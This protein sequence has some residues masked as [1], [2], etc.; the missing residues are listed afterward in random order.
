MTSMEGAAVL[1]QLD[2]ERQSVADSGVRLQTVPYVVRAI[3]LDGSWNGIVY[4]FF[5]ASAN[6]KYRQ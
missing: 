2:R 4:S 1:Y 5:S 6:R 3:A